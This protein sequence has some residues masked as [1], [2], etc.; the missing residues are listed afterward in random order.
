[1]NIAEAP[2]PPP[3]ARTVFLTGANGFVGSHVARHLV[4]LGHSVRALVRKDSDRQRADD[5]RLEWLTG[6]LNDVEALRRGC[7]G[8][9]WVIHSAGRVK[10]P[11]AATYHHTNVT[12]T[13]NLLAAARASA[14]NLRR[15]LY[16]SSLAAGG[17]AP[18]GRPRR[19]S[20]PD[21]PISDY[22][23]SKLAG[24]MAVLSH[25]DT[26]P[27]TV[28][29]P[30]AVYGPG[31]TETLAIFKA[32]RWHI[33]PTF[34][35]RPVRASLVYVT[36]LARAIAVACSHPSA[37]GEMFYVADETVYRLDDLEDM[38][39]Q[40]MEVA[41]VRVRLPAPIFISIAAAVEWSGRMLGVRPALTR[42]RARD[43]MQS[44]WT[45]SVE[46]ARQRL[47]LITA[48]PFSVA[49]QETVQWYRDH[50]WL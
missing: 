49:V 22:G 31:D 32:V 3:P 2:P 33:K 34:G 4:G 12:G 43:F 46:K 36:D 6:D 45:C 42:S 37:V 19:E 47:G 16:I 30:P 14:P 39:Q 11:D 1:M 8:A 15:F 38:M 18:E 24:E 10:A 5:V 41:A 35:A 25:T 40:A 13:K 50:D 20:D 27:I 48:F 26:L 7:D 28:V 44:E 17:P 23:R 21:A 9:D 29:R